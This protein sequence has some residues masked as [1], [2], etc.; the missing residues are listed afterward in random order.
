MARRHFFRQSVAFFV[1]VRRAC[2]L[3]QRRPRP[4]P[5]F[6]V[7]VF[8]VALFRR[9]VWMVS[10]L[11]CRSGRTRLVRGR[12]A[13]GQTLLR[14]R[15]RRVAFVDRKWPESTEWYIRW[16]GR[17]RRL[18]WW[19]KGGRRGGSRRGGSFACRRRRG[20]ERRLGGRAIEVGLFGLCFVSGD[21]VR[22]K[23]I[24]RLMMITVCGSDRPRR[25]LL[26][27]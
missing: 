3:P 17:E 27:M 15:I 10:G 24:C 2:T 6:I 13:G 25:S 5:R 26:L 16:W 8:R 11:F 9:M 14:W 20:L 1:R 23:K 18:H 19:E 21:G 7:R 4:R 12:M 22:G